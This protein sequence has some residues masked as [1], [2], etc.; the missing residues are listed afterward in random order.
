MIERTPAEDGADVE[1]DREAARQLEADRL[2]AVYQRALHGMQ[3][4]VAMKMNHDP[5]ETEPKH[6]RVGINAAMSDQGALAQLLIRKGVITEAEYLQAIAQGM[7][8]ER[9][10]YEQT[11][12]GILGTN[13]KLH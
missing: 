7:E 8:H 4:G 1:R 12:T 6:L 11:L 9:S 13:V 5:K 2:I 10:L 3:A